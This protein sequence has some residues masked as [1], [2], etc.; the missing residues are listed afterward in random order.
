MAHVTKKKLHNYFIK[1][2]GGLY[3]CV[4]FRIMAHADDQYF[5]D[6][7][8]KINEIKSVASGEK[9]CVYCLTYSFR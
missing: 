6:Y 9:I 7:T 8:V 5:P 1:S 4:M 2:M 3:A